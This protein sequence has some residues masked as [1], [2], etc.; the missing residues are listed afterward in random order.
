MRGLSF[1]NKEADLT[2]TACALAAELRR[3]YGP[4][5]AFEL[6]RLHGVEVVSDRW[7]AAAGHL[8]YYGECTREPLRIVLNEAA[9]AQVALGDIPCEWVRELVIAHELGHLLLPRPSVFASHTIIET[10]AHA[11]ARAWTKSAAQPGLREL[12]PLV[13]H[14]IFSG[15]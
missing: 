3:R 12:A 4:V 14:D 5:S 13:L 2:A 9:L 15:Y 8:V 11:F 6:A 7:Q 1:R 10:A